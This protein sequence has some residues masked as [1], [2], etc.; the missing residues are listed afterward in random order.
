MLMIK[1]TKKSQF[2]IKERKKK[3]YLVSERKDRGGIRHF[4]SL[5]NRYLRV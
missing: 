3:Q 4:Q 2:N 5:I 1:N